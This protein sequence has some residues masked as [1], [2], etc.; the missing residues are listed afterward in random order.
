MEP[1]DAACLYKIKNRYGGSVLMS[2]RVNALRFRLHNRTGIITVLNDL[3]GLLHNNKRIQQF[4]VLCTQ[5]NIPFLTNSPLQ[6]KNAYLSGL[7]DSDG[8]IYLN[9]TSQQVFI[10]VSQKDRELLD[11]IC[12]VYGGKVYHANANKTAYK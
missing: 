10:T 3:N 2:P 1:R 12:E 4:S 9:V 8:S 11:M 5:Y 7:F 6:Y